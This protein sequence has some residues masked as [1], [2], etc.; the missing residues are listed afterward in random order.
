[1]NFLSSYHIIVPHLLHPGL[2]SFLFRK[3]AIWKEHSTKPDH[4]PPLKNYII[5]SLIHFDVDE[6]LM[7]IR[8]ERCF[9]LHASRL[10]GKTSCM[11][12]PPM[13]RT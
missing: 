5:D 4:T 6:L 11:R 3:I 2:L 7:L 1:M 9:V 8:Q 10:T 12:H 13:A